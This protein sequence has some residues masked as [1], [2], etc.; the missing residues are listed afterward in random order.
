MKN[1]TEHLFKAE[2]LKYTKLYNFQKLSITVTKLM[3]FVIFSW[4]LKSVVFEVCFY[5]GVY[6]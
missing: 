6:L 5:S 2:F 4:I 1:S 3:V